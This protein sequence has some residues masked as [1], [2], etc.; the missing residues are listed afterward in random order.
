MSLDD[1]GS[2]YKYINMSTFRQQVIQFV[3]STAVSPLER[4]QLAVGLVRADWLV[5]EFLVAAREA[6][7]DWGSIGSALAGRF[8]D[9]GSAPAD[10]S[11]QRAAA[12]RVVEHNGKYRP[13]WEYLKESG[14]NRI[15]LTFAEV[16]RVLGFA[17]PPSSRKHHP[18]WYGYEGSA[19]ARAIVDAGWKAHDVDLAREQVTFVKQ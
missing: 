12:A 19:V 15:S 1:E 14:E 8:E 13:L 2:T 7:C 10:R 16:E 4:L 18:H 5:D 17:L 6:G 11:D 9:V 3:E